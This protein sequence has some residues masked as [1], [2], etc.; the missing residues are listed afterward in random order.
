MSKIEVIFQPGCFD[1]WDG[2]QQELDELTAEIQ[3]LAE[4]GELLGNSQEITDDMLDSLDQ[5]DRQH[6]LQQ[7]NDLVTDHHDRRKNQLH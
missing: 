3:R 1:D 4:S 2:T 7:L 5:H 6:L